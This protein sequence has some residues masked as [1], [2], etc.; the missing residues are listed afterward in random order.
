[1]KNKRAVRT[2]SIWDGN[3][4]SPRIRLE[5]YRDE[6]ETKPNYQWFNA[7]HHQWIECPPLP[8][9]SE[10]MKFAKAAWGKTWDLRTQKKSRKNISKPRK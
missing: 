7:T 3:K 8:S 9:V 5:L 4:N 10:A 1:M 2:A 6:D